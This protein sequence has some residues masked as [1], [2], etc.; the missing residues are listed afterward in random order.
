MRDQRDLPALIA[1][2]DS[3][4]REVMAPTRMEI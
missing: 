4:V 2:L 3:T 1:N